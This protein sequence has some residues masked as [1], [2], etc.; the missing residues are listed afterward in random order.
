MEAITAIVPCYNEAAR[1][2]DV[3]KALKASPEISNI[4]VVNDGSV[5][6]SKEVIS[7]FGVILIDNEKNIGK[8]DSV[9]KAVKLVDSEI[10]LL[11]DADLLGLKKEHVASLVKPVLENR[12]IMAMAV[13]DK[14]WHMG[15]KGIKKNLVLLPINGTRVLQ[16]SI[17]REACEHKLFPQYG[18]EPVINLTCRKRGVKI[19]RIP[20][21]GVK[22]VIKTNKKHYGL[23]PHLE[24]TVNVVSVY[25]RIYISEYKEHVLSAL[26]KITSVLSK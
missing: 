1:V 16:T 19:M 24:E 20:L 18:I 8:G 13:L 2:G 4:I 12:K 25:S 5:D 21:D 10:V 14:Y 17:L 23:K 6:N 9:R 11:C 7:K 22:D 3:L 15:N 26:K